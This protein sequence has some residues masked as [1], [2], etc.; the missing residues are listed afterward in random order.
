MKRSRLYCFPHAGGSSAAYYSW[1]NHIHQSIDIF[2]LDYPSHGQQSNL[3]LCV[4]MKELVDYLYG[5]IAPTLDSID[6]FSFFGYSFGGT[7]AYEVAHRLME[8]GYATPEYLFM[9]AV[10]SP[11]AINKNRYIHLLPD[12]QFREYITSLGGTS[13]EVFENAEWSKIYT[14]ILRNDLKIHELYKFNPYRRPLPC[15][16]TV[17]FGNKDPLVS[18]AIEESNWSK[19]VSKGVDIHSFPGGHFFIQSNLES[20]IMQVTNKLVGED[21]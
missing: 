8:A 12:Q 20:L 5:V 3:P 9:A 14:P 2:S 10:G 6:N 13:K 19:L 7:V 17:F 4:T 1:K 11:A 15:S 16:L 21:L 18:G